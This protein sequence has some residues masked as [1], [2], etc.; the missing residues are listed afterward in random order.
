[1]IT[2][3]SFQP[4]RHSGSTCYDPNNVWNRNIL[5]IY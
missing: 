2:Q 1:M 5:I 3:K 4:R